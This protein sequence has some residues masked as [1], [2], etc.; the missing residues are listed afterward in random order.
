MKTVEVFQYA[1]LMT[2]T[3]GIVLD[4]K[5]A[6]QALISCALTERGAESGLDC[7]FPLRVRVV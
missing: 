2:S 3:S 6:A 4:A 7:F 5:V 1:A